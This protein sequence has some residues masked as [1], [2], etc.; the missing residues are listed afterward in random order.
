MPTSL[1]KIPGTLTSFG[2]DGRPDR[3]VQTELGVGG[4]DNRRLDENGWQINLSLWL[5]NKVQLQRFR[6]RSVCRYRQCDIDARRDSRRQAYC[7]WS[8]AE[9]KL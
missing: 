3:Q 7:E 8:R 2:T 9:L 1:P 6:Y 5:S 4:V